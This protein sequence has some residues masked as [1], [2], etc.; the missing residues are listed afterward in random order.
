M[1]NNQAENECVWEKAYMEQFSIQ[2]LINNHSVD[3]NERGKALDAYLAWNAE[4]LMEALKIK[5]LG[6]EEEWVIVQVASQ[7]PSTWGSGVTWMPF[8]PSPDENLIWH[9]PIMLSPRNFLEGLEACRLAALPSDRLA[10]Q[11]A[12]IISI[13]E[14]WQLACQYTPQEWHKVIIPNFLKVAPDWMRKEAQREG[15]IL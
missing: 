8:L 3:I 9:L 6:Q 5:L 14:Q 12:I 13:K 1:G 4:L 2:Y 7:G 15:W 10:V 11:Q